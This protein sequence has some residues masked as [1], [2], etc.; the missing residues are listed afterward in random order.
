MF[1]EQFTKTVSQ[2]KANIP[3]VLTILAILW[4]IQIINALVKYR[5]NVFGIIPRQPRGVIGIFLS[6]LLHGN[7]AHL[8]FNSIPLFFLADFLLISGRTEF[9]CYTWIIVVISGLLV[10]LFARK[11]VHIGASSVIMG[12]FACVL[13][14]A[15]HR[16]SG[17]SII[18][19]AVTLYYF[20]G[21]LLSLF[22]SDVKTSWEGHVFGFLAGIAAIYL[23]PFI[24]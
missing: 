10:W 22:P 23:C 24:M 2:M 5:L 11:G 19:G 18:I 6:P 1:I 12:Y 8:F 13:A 16:P 20:G 15:F 21:L 7:F 17:V 14:T 3:L 9:F 4:A